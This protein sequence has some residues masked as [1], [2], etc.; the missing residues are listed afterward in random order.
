MKERLLDTIRAELRARFDRLTR[1]AKDAHA[2]ATDPGSKA[3][4]KYDTRSLEASYLAAGQARQVEDL[5]RDM[6][7]FENLSLPNF[8]IDDAI[9]AGALVEADLDGA[10][11]WF[12]L[13]PAAGGLEILHEQR[14]ITLLAPDSSLYRKLLGRRVG[15]S[16][17][18]PPLFVSELL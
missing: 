6:A 9:D 8:D 5:A 17:E 1:A 2:A 11:T 7:L 15:D 3:E 14:D 13:A 12:L 4:S 18:D 16:L 10:S